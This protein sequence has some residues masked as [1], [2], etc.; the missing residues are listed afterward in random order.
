[1]TAWCG[2]TNNGDKRMKITIKLAE[3]H[4]HHDGPGNS[5]WEPIARAANCS[6]EECVYATLNERELTLT[7]RFTVDGQPIKNLVGTVPARALELRA[8][9]SFTMDVEPSADQES[10]GIIWP[11]RS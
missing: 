10:G 3:H 4:F 2:Q 8:G 5:H 11:P 9:A 7:G 6:V 1:M